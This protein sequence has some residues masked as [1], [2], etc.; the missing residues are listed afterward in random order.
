MDILKPPAPLVQSFPAAREFLEGGGWLA[1]VGGLALVLVLVLL[2]VARAVQRAL[3]RKRKKRKQQASDLEVN[4][5][6]IPAP[7]PFRGEKRLQVEGVSVRLR[8]VV[9]A[10]AG[11]AQAVSAGIA[12]KLL[13]R[14]LPGFGTIF[15]EDEPLVLVWPEQL[16]Y[17]GFTNT[18][19][20]NTP[21]PE[22][23]DEPSRWVML[24]GRAQVSGH[25]VLLGLGVQSKKAT[26][27]GRKRLDAHEWP[28]VLRLRVKE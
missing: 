15:D 7:G 12:R 16:S 25:L 1:I 11:R 3:F 19:H 8:L 26:T 23:E 10:P 17:E 20:R 21:L 4:L 22:G 2:F 27:I 6:D 24:A 5:A 9:L 18:F 28:T 14:I 13:D